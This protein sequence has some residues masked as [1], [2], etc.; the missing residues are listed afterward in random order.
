M[1]RRSSSPAAGAL[2]AAAS[3][4][5]VIPVKTYGGSSPRPYDS[6]SPRPFEISNPGG[7]RRLVP[8]TP[9]SNE[10]PR[11][12][13][14]RRLLRE[15]A[16]LVGGQSANFGIS[17]PRAST[18]ACLDADDLI[19][20]TTWR[21]ALFLLETKDYDLVSTT[22]RS[23]AK[24]ARSITWKSLTGSR[25]CSRPPPSATCAVSAAPWERAGGFRTTGVGWR[26]LLRDAPLG[27]ARRPGA[28]GIANI[29]D[30]PC[31]IRSLGR[32]A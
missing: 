22:I 10:E 28:R 24:R 27:C 8:G 16:H 19:R 25:T 32:T 11:T 3:R 18:F 13:S 4:R 29:V 20:P 17:G 1:L 2:A 7:R 30:E 21:R 31:P 14:R 12:P 26:I 6:F 9:G 5:V 23:L 15:G